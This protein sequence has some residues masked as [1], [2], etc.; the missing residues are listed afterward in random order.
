MPQQSTSPVTFSPEESR[1]IRE[2]LSSRE[3]SP[4]CPRC[5]S[6]LRVDCVEVRK[7][8]KLIPF[9]SVVTVAGTR[10]HAWC[11]PCHRAAV[12]NELPGGHWVDL[13]E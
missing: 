1:E 10:W 4:L 7:R 9:T 12:L 5:G 3:E 13:A 8:I 6:T 11:Q 2:R